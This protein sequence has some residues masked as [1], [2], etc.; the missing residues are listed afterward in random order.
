MNIRQAL[1][2]VL[3][4]TSGMI[5]MSTTARA[6]LSPLLCPNGTAPFGGLGWKIDEKTQFFD[7]KTH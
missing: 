7:A 3:W 6:G 5:H 2:G 4:Q 1:G